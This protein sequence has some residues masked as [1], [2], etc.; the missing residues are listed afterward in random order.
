MFCRKCGNEIPDDSVFCLKCGTKVEVLENKT[1][2]TNE[3][4]EKEDVL[5][6]NESVEEIQNE[7]AETI[8]E[9]SI[10]TPE[11]KPK[12]GLWI[13][14][15]AVVLIFIIALASS[16]ANKCD[17]SSCDEEK[18]ADSDY[19]YYHTC[20]EDGCTS[21]KSRGDT[22]CFFHEGEHACT[23]SGCENSKV[24][25]GEYCSEHTCDESGCYNKV[26]YNS[27]YCT[28]HQVDMRKKLGNEFSFSVN[29]A[30]GIELNFRAKNNSGKEIKYIRFDVEFRNAVGDRIQD[31][32]TDDYSVSVEVV[33][34]IK[35]GKSA[36]FEDIIGYNDNC[37]R[38][39]INEVTIIYT[40]GTSQTGHYGWYTEK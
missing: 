12:Y 35:S 22:Y 37:A 6:N 21:S 28:D 33:G 39:D 11:S 8:E 20:R 31:E 24:T 10:S 1:E 9:N 19:C 29:S 30:G 3:A 23:Y 25:G 36:D 32:I 7:T 13:G 14:I 18:E 5:V 17:F 4:K 15:C 27:S 38:I 34:P 26:G 40:D 16:S 2:T